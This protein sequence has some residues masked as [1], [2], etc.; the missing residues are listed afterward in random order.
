MWHYGIIILV[1]CRVFSCVQ[2]PN[3]INN[4]PVLESGGGEL[5]HYFFLFWIFSCVCPSFFYR[6]QKTSY[7]SWLP[8]NDWNKFYPCRSTI[9]RIYKTIYWLTFLNFELRPEFR[10]KSPIFLYG[11]RQCSQSSYNLFR[12]IDTS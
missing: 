12:V 10:C 9:H 5:F 3:K 8:F 4:N 6:I 7:K 11:Y 2:T 1:Q